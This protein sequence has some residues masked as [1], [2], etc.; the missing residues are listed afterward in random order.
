MPRR[1]SRDAR[2]RALG[3]NF[4]RDRAVAADVLRALRPPPGSLIVD[5]GAGD[6]ALTAAAAGAGHRVIAVELD[7]HWVDTLRRQAGAWG[8]VEVVHADALA[9]ALPAAPF[10]V[11]SCVPYAIS[12]RL[13]RRLLTNAHGLIAASLVLQR[14]TARRLAGRPRAGRFAATWAPWYRLEVGRCVPARAFRPVP[15]VESALLAIAP[16]AQP[17]LTPA[18]FEPYVRFLDTVF[19]GRG[20]TIGERLG[21]RSRTPLATAGIPRDAT[22]SA[23]APEA[24]AA[25]FAALM[26]SQVIDTPPSAWLTR[27]GQTHHTSKEGP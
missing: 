23:V 26:T 18:A 16:R 20:R 21:R 22:P 3:Q 4:L 19:A 17:L 12:T 25:L 10:Y 9:V 6:G 13:V 24:Y 5:L 15:Q 27:G 11:M 14:E 1:T 8:D 7:R 2:R